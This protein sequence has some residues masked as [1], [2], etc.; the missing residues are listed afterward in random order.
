[1]Y[2]HLHTKI[3]HF[4]FLIIHV[5]ILLF[6]HKNIFDKGKQQIV[7]KKITKHF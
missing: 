4:H 2:T 7:N 5:K 6:P 1:M 3:S